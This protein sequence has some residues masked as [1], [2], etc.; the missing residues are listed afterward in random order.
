MK[1][2]LTLGI[3]VSLLAFVACEKKEGEG[4]EMAGNEGSSSPVENV[5]SM[6]DSD[7]DGKVT[8]E[9]FMAHF[10]EKDKDGNGVISKEEMKEHHIAVHG[11]ADKFEERFSMTDADDND[12]VNKEECNAKFKKMDA[13][14]D[15][16]LT[17]DE[18]KGMME[19]SHS[20]M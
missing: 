19:K 4:K 6:M 12:E 10:D 9:E 5:I 14:S 7:K 15:G 3:L 8:E 1:K 13:N 20:D 17:A 16:S 2:V 11:N 18:F